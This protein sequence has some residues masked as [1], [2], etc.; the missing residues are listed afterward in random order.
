MVMDMDQEK[1]SIIEEYI[2]KQV[3]Q[4]NKKHQIISQETVDKGISLFTSSAYSKYTLA[5]IEQAIDEEIEKI[6]EEAKKKINKIEKE[7]R[8]EKYEP[9]KEKYNKSKNCY[10]NIN[11]WVMQLEPLNNSQTYYGTQKA[12]L[13]D[14]ASNI[15]DGFYKG[16]NSP[17]EYELLASRLGKI[18]NI[19]VADYFLEF[20]DTK[21]EIHGISIS[22][23]ENE[24]QTMF[25]GYALTNETLNSE[26]C[27]KELKT[28]LQEMVAIAKKI[29]EQK[30]RNP[31]TPTPQL[32]KEET[33]EY[34]DLL[35]KCFDYKIKDKDQLEQLKKDYFNSVL[36][37]A[38]IDQKDYHLSNIGILYNKKDNSYKLSPLFDNGN[39]KKDES[40][41]G[42]INIIFGH[43]EKSD[44]IDMLFSDYYDYIS[45]FSKKLELEKEK[46]NNSEDNMIDS[47]MTCID[48]TI[49]D[50]E[51]EE[52]K[53][54]VSSTINEVIK[55]EKEKSKTNEES[56][57]QSE[58]E[59]ELSKM[60]S[61]AKGEAETK[62]EAKTNSTNTPHI[63]KLTNSS[64]SASSNPSSGTSSG[65]NSGFTSIL[66]LSL[67]LST[68]AI[69]LSLLFIFN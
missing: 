56:I 12:T 18:C 32:T 41:E 58:K 39:C 67:I 15:S 40:I 52:Y 26:D 21:K 31:N 4:A 16:G 68:M 42:K 23:I 10:H 8:E 65:N 45:D 1:S 5:Q 59:S 27:P 19:P 50:H 13:I 3:E 51:A 17:N 20:D 64:P 61:E 36:F 28:S 14:Y 29:K 22:C 43:S 54:T 35:V 9:L 33:K 34:M 60:I 47:M 66:T 37:N 46:Q 57:S 62:G 11:R 53:D 38:I 24:N 25:D 63:K 30:D 48:D 49:V 44:V 7:K 55:K 2:K 69:L 6:K